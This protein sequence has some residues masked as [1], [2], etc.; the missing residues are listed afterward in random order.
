VGFGVVGAGELTMV[1]VE[2]GVVLTGVVIAGV[3]GVGEGV[4]EAQPARIRAS[5]MAINSGI[6]FLLIYSSS[7]FSVQIIF[8]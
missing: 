2:T 6:N 1:V 4:E 3:V 5:R 8:A 7:V